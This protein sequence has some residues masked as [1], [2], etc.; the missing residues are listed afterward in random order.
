MCPK[1]ANMLHIR[2]D[3][4]DALMHQQH[5]LPGGSFTFEHSSPTDAQ[6]SV[7]AV[8]VLF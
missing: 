1:L 2:Y 6:G 5:D 4:I 8:F 7:T 3:I